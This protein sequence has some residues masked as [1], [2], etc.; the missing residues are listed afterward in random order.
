MKK[1]FLSIGNMS[2][3][4]GIHIKSLRYYENIGVL[5]PAYVDP[6]TKYRYYSYQQIP[7]VMAL[8]F[9][10]ELGIPLINS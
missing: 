5:I 9:C 4:T 10:L 3:L 6:Q 7:N 1:S 2:K 8:R